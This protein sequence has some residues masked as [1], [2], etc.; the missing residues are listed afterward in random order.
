MVRSSVSINPT[1]GF[2]NFFFFFL[3]CSGANLTDRQFAGN[4][5][6]KTYHDNDLNDVLDRAKENGVEKMLVTGSCLEESK[7]GIELSRNHPNLLYSTAGVHPCSS[8]RFE[9]NESGPEDYLKQLREFIKTGKGSIKAFGEI[10]LDYDRLNFAPAD[11]QRKY[12]QWQLDLA[13]EFP[14][15]P[16]FLHSRACHEDFY[17]MLSPY[18]KQGKLPKGGVVHSFTGTVEEVKELVDL[19]LYIGVNGCSLKTQE[20]LDVVKEIPLSHLMLETDGPWCE[21]RPSHASHQQYLKDA[22]LEKL[23]PYKSVKKEKFKQGMMVKGRCEPCSIVLVAEVIAGV[24]GVSVEEVAQAAW[25]NTQKVF[26]M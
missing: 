3:F 4:Y 7:A 11:I 13:T 9:N 10:G 5:H 2:A 24:K 14:E 25:E 16:L 23:L 12:F 19:G 6:G 15:L 22:P 17:K 21:I 18:I 1:Q 26:D 20:N 8:L